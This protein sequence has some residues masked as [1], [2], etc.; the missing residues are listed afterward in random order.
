MAS[1]KPFITGSVIVVLITLIPSIMSVFAVLPPP[2]AY[3]VTFAIFTKMVEMA[4]RELAT[5][6]KQERAYKVTAV[7]LM[8]GVGIM[9]IPQKSMLDLPNAI[10]AVLSNGLIVGTI[11]AIIIEQFYLWNERRRV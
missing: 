5:E 7:G 9:F 2:V 11:I 4:F 10:A 8:I 1:L 3:A 6:P